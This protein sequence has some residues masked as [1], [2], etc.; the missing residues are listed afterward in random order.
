MV[1]YSRGSNFLRL[2]QN[3]FVDS[4]FAHIVRDR[5]GPRKTEFFIFHQKPL[6]KRMAVSAIMSPKITNDRVN[7][8]G[9]IR[10]F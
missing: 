10:F 3:R 4:D 8:H 1:S 6:P 9:G 7:F 2:I 5:R